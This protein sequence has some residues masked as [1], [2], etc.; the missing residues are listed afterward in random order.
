MRRRVL[1]TNSISMLLWS[2]INNCVFQYHFGCFV[3]LQCML[4]ACLIM[5]QV[6]YCKNLSTL[7]L[8]KLT[9]LGF[10]TPYICA[11]NDVSSWKCERFETFGY[12]TFL[13]QSIIVQG[14]SCDFV[15]TRMGIFPFPTFGQNV[16]EHHLPI[17]ERDEAHT[18]EMGESRWVG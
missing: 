9:Y 17:P 2:D 10:W 15:P 18:I 5:Q 13:G 4:K 3:P 14:K 8:G 16:Q 12:F 11:S 7:N 6:S 1:F